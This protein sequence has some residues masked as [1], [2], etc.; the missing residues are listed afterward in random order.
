MDQAQLRAIVEAATRHPLLG[1]I[2]EDRV[3]VLLLNRQLDR[4]SGQS[5]AGYHKR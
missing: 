3:N 4:R 1:L 5:T 2:G